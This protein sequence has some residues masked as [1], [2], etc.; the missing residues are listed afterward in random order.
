METGYLLHRFEHSVIRPAEYGMFRI[1]W[2]FPRDASHEFRISGL[3][4]LGK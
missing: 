4:E 1:W 3:S 2:L